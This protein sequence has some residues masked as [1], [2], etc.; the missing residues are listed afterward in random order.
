VIAPDAHT[1]N[2]TQR[3]AFD[4]RGHGVITAGG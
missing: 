3:G 1:P 2:G 4:E